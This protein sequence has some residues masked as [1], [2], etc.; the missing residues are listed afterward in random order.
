MVGQIIG[1]GRE[2]YFRLDSIG[3]EQALYFRTKIERP[4]IS[5]SIVER[6]HPQAIARDEKLAPAL[7]PNSERKHSPQLLDAAGP[8]F[9]LQLEHG[10]RIAMRAINVTASF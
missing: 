5:M 3:R 4:I 2:I 7:V 9:F 8:I 10:F 6:F 1:E